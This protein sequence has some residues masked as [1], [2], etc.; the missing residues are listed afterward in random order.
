MLPQN[1]NNTNANTSSTTG[2]NNKGGVLTPSAH[3]VHTLI[4]FGGASFAQGDRDLHTSRHAHGAVPLLAPP[5]IG[6]FGTPDL[7]AKWFERY[8]EGFDFPIGFQW[9]LEHG[10]GLFGAPAPGVAL[11]GAD[12][13]YSQLLG[14]SGGGN[15]DKDGDNQHGVF[16]AWPSEP[17]S[18]P[19][20]FLQHAAGL[21]RLVDK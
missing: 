2:N 9:P 14:G 3:E 8:G 20:H 16:V 12:S 4:A 7:N 1:K 5:H 21:L 11:V 10:F 13:A 18:N 17:L 15:D 19:W 6:K